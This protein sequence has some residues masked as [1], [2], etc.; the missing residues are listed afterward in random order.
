VS[1]IPEVVWNESG[2]GAGLW[3]S[4]GGTSTIYAKP[5]WQVGTGVPADGKR[6]VPDV[7][8]T[9]AGHDGYLIY[10]EGGLYVVGGTSAAS[11]SFA[12]IMA[13]VVQ[14]T[15]ARQGNANSVFYPL[16]TKQTAGGVSVF[17]DITSGSNTVPG[18]NG[19]NAATGYNQATGLGSIDASVLVSHW[20]D[21][22][23]VPAFQLKAAA[24]SLSVTAGSNNSVT[25]NVTVSGGFDAAVAFSVTGLPAGMSAAFTPSTLSAPGSGNSVLKLTA[26]NA[27]KPGIYAATLVAASGS[28]QHTVLLSLTVAPVSTFTLRSSTA[29]ISVRAGSTRS[30]TVTTTPN[31]TFNATITLAVTGLPT[32]MRVQI[33]PSSVVAAPGAGATVVTFS[34]ASNVKVKTYAVTLTATGGGVIQ[35]QTLTVNVRHRQPQQRR[36]EVL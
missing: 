23:V 29:S 33:L 12:G 17:H 5:S 20:N 1:Y 28:T 15:A 21:G 11:P 35:R 2:S 31:P 34:A 14:G 3:S 22:N 8:L 26:T 9:S 32:G 25:L 4:G 16:A 10:Q 36:R 6:D 13:L 27:T 19:F 7:S 18:Q 24:S 30:L